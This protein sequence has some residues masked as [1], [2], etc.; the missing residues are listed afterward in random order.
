MSLFRKPELNKIRGKPVGV[1][2]VTKKANMNSLAKAVGGKDSASLDADIA[3][4]SNSLAQA[5][6]VK[7]GNSY[8]GSD[9]M[10]WNRRLT[11][12]QNPDIGRAVT[13]QQARSSKGWQEYARC[14]VD[15][16]LRRRI[17]VHTLKSGP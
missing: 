10:W 2:D 17:T 4:L 12:E 7:K 15:V 5:E 11:W 8:V 9:L 1:S 3:A 14:K 6:A 16:L 13:K